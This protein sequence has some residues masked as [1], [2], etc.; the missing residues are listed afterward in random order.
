MIGPMF[1]VRQHRGDDMAQAR[2]RVQEAA[3]ESPAAA[4]E[5]SAIFAG[6]LAAVGLTII[7][8]TLGAGLGFSAVSPWTPRYPSP[9]TFTVAAGLWLIGTQWLSSAL[10]GYLT[11]RLRAKWVGVRTDEVYFRDTAHG[12]FAWALGTVI[13]AFLF[14]LGSALAGSA[15]VATGAEAEQTREAAEQARQAAATFGFFTALSLLVGAFIGSLC[16]AFGGYHR[17]AT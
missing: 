8:L 12:F 14:T 10:G 15:A 6:G 17:D 1:F 3:V 11:G 9:L 7:L 5:W 4:V 16:G 13:M 2:S